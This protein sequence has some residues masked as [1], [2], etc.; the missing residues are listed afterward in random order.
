MRKL[1]GHDDLPGESGSSSVRDD[2]VSAAGG[3]APEPGYRLHDF[4]RRWRRLS[5]SQ[6]QN[7]EAILRRWCRAA[8]ARTCRVLGERAELRLLGLRQRPYRELLKTFPF[9][10][11]LYLIDAPPATAPFL[12]EAS[13]ALLLPVLERMLG[14]DAETTLPEGRC[15]TRAEIAVVAHLIECWLDTLR[16]SWE[17]CEELR[18]EIVAHED[19]PSNANVIAPDENTLLVGFELTVAHRSGRVHLCF[20]VEPFSAVFSALTRPPYARAAAPRAGEPGASP[21]L[22]RVESS[23]VTL[24]AT[25]EPVPIRLADVLALRAGDVIDTELTSATPVLVQ[26]EGKGVFRAEAIDRNGRRAVRLIERVSRARS[27]S[28]ATPVEDEPPAAVP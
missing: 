20:P 13:P 10:T 25:L 4:R 22:R 16:A 5:E 24:S 15:M 18:F 19:V 12:L 14:G 2:S 8:A 17:A 23:S 6:L 26:I 1:P 3:P 9:P 21:L 28:A 27:A 11:S 7:L